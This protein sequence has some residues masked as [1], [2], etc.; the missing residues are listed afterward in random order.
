MLWITTSAI[1]FMAD[2]IQQVAYVKLVGN[3]SFILFYTR[4]SRMSHMAK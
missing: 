4:I 2:K 3:S 1:L